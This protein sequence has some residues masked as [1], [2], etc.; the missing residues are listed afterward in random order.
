LTG[1]ESAEARREG[2]NFYGSREPYL[3]VAARPD[4]LVF[5]TAPTPAA[6]TD[7]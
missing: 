3:P 6:R 1:A 7:E 2:P 4:V 5:K